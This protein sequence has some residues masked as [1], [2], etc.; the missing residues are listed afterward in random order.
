MADL[1]LVQDALALELDAADEAAARHVRME[2]ADNSI[3]AYAQRWKAWLRHCD[4]LGIRPAPV[5]PVEL[6]RYLSRLTLAGKAPN[7][8]RLTLSAISVV[9]QRARVTER[10]RHPVSVRSDPLVVAWYDGWARENPIA[11]RKKAPHVTV[12]QLDLLLKTAQERPRNVSSQHHVAAYSRDRAML[13]IG[14]HACMR[15][16]ELVALQ[17]EHV[18]THPRGLRVFVAATKTDPHGRGQW[19]AVAPAARSLRCPVDAWLTWA[20]VRGSWS[21]AA[22]CPIERD[23]RRVL[24]PLSDAAARRIVERRAKA[25]GISMSSHSMRATFATLAGELG[26]PAQKVM[27][28]GGWHRVDTAIGYM[29]QGELFDDPPNAGLLDGEP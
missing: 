26:K 9:D 12:S 4:E 23:G 5:S 3:R 28:Q 15:I 2:K 14:I 16:S 21:G 6:I 18:E 24:E 22:F 11:P 17:L 7:T 27:E 8:V 19:R 29:R 1:A 20:T 10:E 13:L 25:C